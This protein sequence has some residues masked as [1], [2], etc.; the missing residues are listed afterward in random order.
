MLFERDIKLQADDQVTVGAVTRQ[1][2]KVAEGAAYDGSGHCAACGAKEEAFHVFGCRLEYC[3]VCRHQFP[4]CRCFGKKTK[5]EP[6]L[7]GPEVVL[8][9]ETFKRLRVGGESRYSGL[10]CCHDCAAGKGVLHE[11]GCDMEECPRCGGQFAFCGCYQ[12]PAGAT[13]EAEPEVGRHFAGDENQI[14]LDL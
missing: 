4:Y 11:F 8:G 3:P 14:K 5:Q 9:G 12:P 1:R 6:P 13:P 7:L 10:E 2:L